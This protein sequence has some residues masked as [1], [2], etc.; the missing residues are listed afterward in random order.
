[1]A[2]YI[3]VQD[4]IWLSIALRLCNATDTMYAYDSILYRVTKN[5]GKCTDLLA[6]PE[7]SPGTYKLCFDTAAFF[8]AQGNLQHFYPYVEV[9]WETSVYSL[10]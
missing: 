9:S 6:A 7:L 8:A 3:H 5:D 4:L 2:Y 10:P 1:M